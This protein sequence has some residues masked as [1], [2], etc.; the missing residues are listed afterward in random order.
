MNFR[1][2]SRRTPVLQIISMIDILIILLIFLVVS[3]SFKEPVKARSI[4]NLNI[5]TSASLPLATDKLERISLSITKDQKIYLAEA[6]TT[7]E[8]LPGL[9]ATLRAQNP[10]AKLDLALDEGSSLKV[11]I[12]LYDVLTQAGFDALQVPARMLKAAGADVRK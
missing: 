3:T 9:L 1:H 6:E 2:R 4:L 7:L 8:A 5:P 10:G 11:M 12:Q